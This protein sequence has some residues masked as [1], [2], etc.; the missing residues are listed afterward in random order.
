MLQ[1]RLVAEDKIIAFYRLDNGV[2]LL[3]LA[4]L[5]IA[6][7]QQI[8]QADAESQRADAAS[9][10]ADAASQRADAASQRADAASQRTRE[11]EAQIAEY[12]QQLGLPPN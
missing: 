6:L 12:Q 2:K 8:A 7:E 3:P 4:E 9:Q 1:L 11:L 10:R 5:N